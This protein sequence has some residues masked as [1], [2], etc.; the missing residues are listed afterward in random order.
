M[1]TLEQYNPRYFEDILTDMVNMLRTVNPELTDY[2]VG[3][4]IRTILEAAAL[5]D[6]EQYHQMTAL[7]LLWN[8]D[9]IRGR[10][11]DER[12][13]EWNL[14]RFEALPAHGYV[15]VSNND[16]VTS[17]LANST[18]IGVTAITILSS[19][20]F[21]TVGAFTAR[22]G[23]GTTEEETLSVA[24]NNV[25][26]G[27]LSLSVPVAKNHYGGDRV[28]LVQGG[29]LVAGAGQ[30]IRV[31]GAVEGYD[32][33]ATLLENATIDAGDYDSNRVRAV[34]D[35]PGTIGRVAAGAFREF[36]GTAPFD[37]ALVRNDAPFFGGRDEES[38]D[39]FRSR[40][41]N[42]I[43]SL[44]RSTRLAL[45]QL[46]LGISY[47]GLDGA[48]WRVI[49]AKTQE[50][51]GHDG[52]DWVYLYI[53][54]GSFDF[55]ES[56]I[57]LAPES[58]TSAAEDGQKFFKLAHPAV[59]PDSLFLEY[60]PAGGTGWE[61]LIQGVHYYLNE[62]TGWLEIIDPTL[63]VVSAFGPIRSVG[64]NK[65]DQLRAT[66]YRYYTGL[67]QQ[68]QVAVNGVVQNPTVYP[69]ISAAGVKVLVTFP[70]AK[71][72]RD[73]RASIQVNPGYTEASVSILVQGFLSR[74]LTELQIGQD[75]ILAE[76]IERAMG[77]EGM[78]N[79]QFS[80]PTQDITLLEDEIIDQEDLDIFVS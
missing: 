13:L 51:Y 44:S 40:G 32:V 67:I 8:L 39:E 12:L 21:P 25:S 49:S 33:T 75:I 66:Q 62:G 20:G 54:P 19:A 80:S 2:N 63:T 5:E 15:I 3:S 58:L 55:I 60:Y 57:T 70:R 78:Y 28:S 65:G 53:W 6:D 77:T 56:V 22:V 59:V 72:I 36:V 14:S 69:G 16:L 64:L 76:M 61:P 73:I 27:T 31:R 7:L 41:R 79:V 48:S 47:T 29:P 23:E 17:F 42:K 52:N 74:Y 24:S 45:E 37:G 34:V 46:V 26:T 9:N 43:Q 71:K 30:R 68:V 50:F 1:G 11:L 38:D 10:D 35:T 4:R 18:A